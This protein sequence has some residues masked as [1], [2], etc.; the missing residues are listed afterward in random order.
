ML[1]LD[2]LQLINFQLCNGSFFSLPFYIPGNIFLT[3]GIMNFN[4]AGLWISLYFDKK[5]W[6]FLRDRVKLLRNSDILG[7]CLFSGGKAA[8]ILSTYAHCFK[9]ILLELWVF[10]SYWKT[11]SGVIPSN[12]FNGLSPTLVSSHICTDQ[13]FWTPF[14]DLYSYLYVQLSSPWFCASNTSCLGLPGLSF[15]S[16]FLFLEFCALSGP[17]CLNHIWCSLSKP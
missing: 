3:I 13:D 5:F 14:E 16:L 1:V 17:P 10:Y 15:V 6:I 12:P 2:S 7:S 11:T 9:V 8:V 4:L